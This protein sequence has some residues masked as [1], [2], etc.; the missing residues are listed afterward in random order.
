MNTN[1]IHAK[2]DLMAAQGN[3]A[4]LAS[5]AADLLSSALTALERDNPDVA[6]ER[7]EVAYELIAQLA[8]R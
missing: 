1:L 4:R 5:E 3:T 6:Y 7:I 2:A 8:R